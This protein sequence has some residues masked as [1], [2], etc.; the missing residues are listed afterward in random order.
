[1]SV[2]HDELNEWNEAIL[3]TQNEVIAQAKHAINNTLKEAPTKEKAD[4]ANETPEEYVTK[5]A[6]LLANEKVDSISRYKD[7]R[8]QYEATVQTFGNIPTGNIIAET[9]KQMIEHMYQEDKKVKLALEE[10]QKKLVKRHTTLN[11]IAEK[12]KFPK[13]AADKFEIVPVHKRTPLKVGT[14]GNTFSFNPKATNVSSFNT[15]LQAKNLVS[16]NHME[17]PVFYGDVAEWPAFYMPFKKIVADVEGVEDVIKHNI[18][19]QHLRGAPYDLVKPYKTDGSE[20]K[21]ALDRL[22]L[23]YDSAEK[24]HAYLWNKLMNIPKAKDNAS[25]LRTLHNELLATTNSLKTHDDIEQLN[26]QAIVKS[27]LPRGILI[28][29]L[30]S[31]PKKTSEILAALD[32]IATIEESAFESNKFEREDRSAFSVN[33]KQ[34]RQQ[35]ACKFCQRTNHNTVECKTIASLSERKEFIKRNKLC[36]NCMSSSHRSQDCHSTACKKCNVKHNQAICPKNHS[37]SAQT[38]YQ[39]NSQNYPRNQNETQRNNFRNSNEG[40]RSHNQQNGQSQW[41]GQQNNNGNSQWNGNQQKQSQWNGNQNQNRNSQWNG[42]TNGPQ[43]NAKQSYGQSYGQN[44]NGKTPGQSAPN[45]NTKNSYTVSAY[46]TSLMVAKAPILIDDEIETIPVLLDSGADQSFILSDFAERSNMKIIEKNLEFNINAFGKE[47][48][49]IVVNKVE[50]E[51]L[52]ND[53]TCL[54]VEALTVPAITDL[55]DPVSLSLEDREFLE[56]RNQ[57][58]I[59]ITRPE[60]AIALLGCDVFW[61]LMSDQRKEK[62][63]SGRFIIPTHIGPVICGKQDE[64]VT[65]IHALIARINNHSENTFTETSLEEYFEISN[66]GITDNVEDVTNDEIVEEFKKSVEINEKSKRIVVSLPWKEG[67]KEKLSNN[68][69][70]A[71]YQ[72]IPSIFSTDKV[73]KNANYGCELTMENSEKNGNGALS[74]FLHARN[75]NFLDGRNFFNRQ[76]T[77]RPPRLP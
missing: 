4:L 7:Y 46:Q 15:T 33:S 51:I 3:E 35:K 44:K 34:S 31:E 53:N 52:T 29:V 20:F 36:F 65:S 11:E 61:N 63:P 26:F 6:V 5:Y 18:L 71:Y 49:T 47:P 8:M 43:Q 62:L 19:R 55:F 69:D 23:M 68:K 42:K 58:T 70:V 73:L 48:T 75:C 9:A 17:L 76:R 54:K 41:K 30:K 64:N 57:T 28:E 16:S 13:I 37:H 40:Q 24:Q 12:E 72:I 27:K 59:N 25:S 39:K 50:F 32:K 77:T 22:V 38:Q 21:T 67:Q 74:S 10:L 45:K 60:K 56:S 14:G 1:M 66:I 2:T